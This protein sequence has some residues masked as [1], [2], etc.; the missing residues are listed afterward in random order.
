MTVYVS[1]KQV[2][3]TLVAYIYQR[4]FVGHVNRHWGAFAKR[5]IYNRTTRHGAKG[6]GANRV[7]FEKDAPLGK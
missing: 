1:N 6:G 5:C 4:L 3:N 7:L 2:N